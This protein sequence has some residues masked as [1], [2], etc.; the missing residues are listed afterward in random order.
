MALKHDIRLVGKKILIGIIIFLIPS[1]IIIGGLR[2]VNHLLQ[3]Q[4]ANSSK[5][6]P[7]TI[8]Q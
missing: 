2:L 8:N 6:N 3:N 1:F 7:T 4:Q 5:I